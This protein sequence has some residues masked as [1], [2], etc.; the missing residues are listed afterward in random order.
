M[1]VSQYTSANPTGTEVAPVTGTVDI[2][3][4]ARGGD[5][6]NASA[7]IG[8]GGGGGGGCAQHSISVTAGDQVNVNIA[9]SG[10]SFAAKVITGTGGFSGISLRGNQGASGAIV[11]G[12]AGGTAS[13]GN[14][15]NVSGTD[16]DSQCCGIGG[17]GGTR[18]GPIGGYGDGG[19]GGDAPSGT[20]DGRQ[21][22]IIRFTYTAAGGSLIY[23]GG[24]RSFGHMILRRVIAWIKSRRPKWAM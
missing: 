3:C 9:D 17:A 13:G 21:G 12:G 11:T 22:A 6:G 4:Q 2:V 10:D 23:D 16:G 7:F 8:G 24:R 15:S 5:G 14:V 20:G 19:E 1:T 18:G